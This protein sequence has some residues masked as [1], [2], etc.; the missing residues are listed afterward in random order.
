MLD[1]TQSTQ[2]HCDCKL[3]HVNEQYQLRDLNDELIRRRQNGDASLRDLASYVNLRI[4]DAAIERA[5]GDIVTGDN[6]LYGALEREEAIATIYETLT[7][8]EIAPE[9]RARVRTRLDQA[10]VDLDVVEDD[11]L[12]HPTVRNHLLECLGID[13]S[14]T[15]ELDRDGAAKTIEWARSRCVAV[16]GRTLQR[17]QTVGQLT[18]TNADVSLSIRITCT[19]CQE[20]YSPSQLLSQGRCACT[21][22]DPNREAADI[23]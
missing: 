13:T 12:T 20:T 14:P 11:W 5:T 21:S 23:G 4:L 6:D 8:E 15:R 1:H 7:D 2:R 16:I 10:R 9:R 3:G 22:N 17:L 18:I 19:E